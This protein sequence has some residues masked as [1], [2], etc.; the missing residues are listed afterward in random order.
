MGCSYNVRGQLPSQVCGK[1]CAPLCGTKVDL[2][3]GV[4][5]KT[6][7]VA[8][9]IAPQTMGGSIILLINHSETWC[10]FS[11][12]ECKWGSSE[13][14]TQRT[15]QLLYKQ[16]ANL[17]PVINRES[18]GFWLPYTDRSAFLTA[19]G[20]QKDQDCVPSMSC[21]FN[22]VS[23]TAALFTC[24]SKSITSHSKEPEIKFVLAEQRREWVGEYLRCRFK[25]SN[26][27]ESSW[28]CVILKST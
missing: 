15:T 25:I 19:L 2:C 13:R 18:A 4:G 22:K 5:G 24:K 12:Q 3:Q 17:R 9:L 7:R 28:S 14:H 8:P 21:V 16:G 27:I 20:W 1:Q 23:N 26:P 6:W 10:F 11:F